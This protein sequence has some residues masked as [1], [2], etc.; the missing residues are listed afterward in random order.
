MKT[1]FHHT[2]SILLAVLV[3]LSTVSWTVDK[4]FCMGR[5]M[6]ISLFVD[7]E[8]CGMEVAMAAMED[9]VMENHCCDDES[10]TFTG[11]DDLKLS[12]YDLEIE[13][14]DFLVAFTYS[15][16]NLFVP[17]DKLPVPN[18]K[19]PPPLLVKDITVLDQVFLI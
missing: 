19:Y 10:F 2:I 14:Q 17:V 16:L 5:V 11:Q 9:K 8:E 18:E 6:D 7:A 1:V 15:Y 12:L 4:H 13:H 3:L